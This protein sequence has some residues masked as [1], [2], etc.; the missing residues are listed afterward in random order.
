MQ[1]VVEYR[2]KLRLLKVRMLD[3]CVKSIMVDDSQIVAHLMVF[4]CTKIGILNHE[5]YSLVADKPDEEVENL[6][7]NRF[8]TLGN[9]TLTLKRQKY[10][11][12]EKE[13][14]PKL[15]A[16]KRELNTEDGGRYIIL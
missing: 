8:G 7:T 9:A 13:I 4:I 15:E 5:E 10:K 16:M 12:G 3:N 1:D 2:R 6:P 11:E 14:D